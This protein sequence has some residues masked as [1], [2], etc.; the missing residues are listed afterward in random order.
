MSCMTSTRRQQIVEQQVCRPIFFVEGLPEYD[1]SV[2]AQDEVIQ[3]MQKINDKLSSQVG[4]LEKELVAA[5]SVK[6]IE[7][8]AKPPPDPDASALKRL[9]AKLHAVEE[10]SKQ[11]DVQR[12]PLFYPC[13]I[14][15][16]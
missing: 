8:E 2:A 14:S 9:K 7:K 13:T 11:K 16:H 6:V 12:E 3:T 10:E 1:A 15:R 5:K 4:S